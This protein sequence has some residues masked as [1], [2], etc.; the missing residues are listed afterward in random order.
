M[1]KAT[2][3]VRVVRDLDMIVPRRLCT[4]RHRA[5]NTPDDDRTVRD[6]I[7]DLGIALSIGESRLRRRESR[8]RA[9][10]REDANDALA[11]MNLGAVLMQRDRLEEAEHWFD[12][13]A[14]MQRSLPD[15]GRPGPGPVARARPPAVKRRPR[16][17][18]R[19]TDR[20]GYAG[21]LTGRC[22]A[23]RLSFIP[24]RSATSRRVTTMA[25]R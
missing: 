5:E 8:L 9:R 17:P 19:P 24:S 23:P 20:P 2:V 21:A 7:F 15:G 16:P 11:A 22:M 3:T 4:I 6:V 25:R 12:Q 18:R 1:P 14:A 10:L 13:A